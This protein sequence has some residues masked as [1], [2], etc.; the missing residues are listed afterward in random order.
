M[1]ASFII[2]SLRSKHG[3]TQSEMAQMLGISRQSYNY[4]E[5]NPTKAPLEKIM[6]IFKILNESIDDF[7]YVL[8]QDYMS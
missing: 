5:N 8:K 3:K 4:I 2:K 1:K 7:L 6:K